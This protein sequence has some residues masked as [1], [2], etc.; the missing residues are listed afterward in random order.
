MLDRTMRTDGTFSPRHLVPAEVN[1]CRPPQPL[2]HSGHIRR[3]FP[4]KSFWATSGFQLT[5]AQEGQ[6]STV[7]Q[8]Y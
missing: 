1:T 8:L 3:G 4:A 2:V 5:L 6:M 7:C